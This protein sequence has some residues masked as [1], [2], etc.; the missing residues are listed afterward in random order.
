M[1]QAAHKINNLLLSNS[2]E[3]ANERLVRNHLLFAAATVFTPVRIDSNANDCESRTRRPASHALRTSN[4][5]RMDLRTL[6]WIKVDP[7]LDVL[8]A[9]PRFEALVRRVG[10][11]L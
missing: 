1:S 7:N 9:E 5:Q 11:L 4:R 10:F 3:N 8:R 2:T 6:N